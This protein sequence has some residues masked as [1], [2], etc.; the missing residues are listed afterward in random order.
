MHYTIML[1]TGLLPLPYKA[2]ASS[3][4]GPGVFGVTLG[5]HIF[6]AEAAGVVVEVPPTGLVGEVVVVVVR[7]TQFVVP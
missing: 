6:A 2:G 3:E 4:P 1:I 5:G 7:G